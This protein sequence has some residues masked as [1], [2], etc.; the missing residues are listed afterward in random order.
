MI[1]MSH[2]PWVSP[3][4]PIRPIAFDGSRGNRQP[5]PPLLL[6][7]ATMDEHERI[8]AAFGDQPCGD[9]GLSE[10]GR[11]RQDAGVVREH[12]LGRLRCSGYN[13]PRNVTAA[14]YRRSARRE[15]LRQSP[16]AE[17]YGGPRPDNPVAIRCG[18]GDPLHRR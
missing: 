10:R 5:L 14:A 13:S 17:R 1:A 3:P 16:I 7:L 6:Q 2:D 4:P 8:H 15:S 18:A 11:G 12:V 9:D